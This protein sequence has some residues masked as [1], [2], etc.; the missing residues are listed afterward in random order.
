MV[1][2]LFSSSSSAVCAHPPNSHVTLASR[3]SIHYHLIDAIEQRKHQRVH[4]QQVEDQDPT[5]SC[6]RSHDEHIRSQYLASI[7]FISVAG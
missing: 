1:I 3:P 5:S 7:H 4:V 2:L 6:V